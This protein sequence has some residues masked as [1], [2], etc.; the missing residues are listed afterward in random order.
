MYIQYYSTYNILQHILNNWNVLQQSNWTTKGKKRL[1]G[2]GAIALVTDLQLV[3]SS[4]WASWMLAVQQLQGWPEPG[5]PVDRLSHKSHIAR[6]NGTRLHYRVK[7]FHREKLP[8]PSIF[9]QNLICTHTFRTCQSVHTYL[10]A[11]EE[12]VRCKIR[13]DAVDYSVGAKAIVDYWA[14]NEDIGS[15]K[16][17]CELGAKLDVETDWDDE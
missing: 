9:N 17:A 6:L 1:G 4:T 14:I 15:P 5:Y 2:S 10:E 7:W 13:G 12:I 8:L 3:R 11:I 16:I